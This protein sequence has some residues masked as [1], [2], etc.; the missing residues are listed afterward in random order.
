MAVKIRLQRHGRKQAPFYHIVVADSR[1]PRDGRFL[2]RVGTYN[3]LT[4]PA[5]I[6]IDRD[7]AFDWLMKGAEPTETVAAIFRFKGIMYRKHL[8][9]GV[10][11]G[12]FTQEVADE[13]Y[14]KWIEEKEGKISVIREVTKKETEDFHK[15]LF[16]APKPK[17]VVEAPVSE[18]ETPAEVAEEGETPAEDTTAEA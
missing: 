1:S 3:P 15:R 2:E 10:R 18:E 16:G 4:K 8:A 13:M 11:K 12:A 7:L 6:E 14:A 17:K 5:T 9:R